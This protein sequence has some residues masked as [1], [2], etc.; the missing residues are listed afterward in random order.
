MYETLE[1]Q[2]VGEGRLFGRPANGERGDGQDKT[3]QLQDVDNLLRL[4]DGG[5]QIAVAQS[6]F[7]H[8]IAEC[9]R[10]EQGID[11]SILER[12]EVVVARL[13]LAL[14]APAC[15][16]VEVG[17]DGEHYGSLCHHGLVEVGG[18]QALL[19]VAIAGDDD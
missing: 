16:A 19:H 14:L 1:G 15:G 6:L 11:G 8:E 17:T 9:L 12:Q 7:V 3:R 13:S 2:A 18:S 4:V 10:I 5:A